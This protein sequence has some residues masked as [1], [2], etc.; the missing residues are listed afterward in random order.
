MLPSFIIAASKAIS[1]LFKLAKW[2]Y[3]QYCTY[4]INWI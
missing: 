4:I 1:Y 2:S 3:L